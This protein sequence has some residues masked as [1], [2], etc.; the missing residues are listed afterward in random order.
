MSNSASIRLTASSAS[1]EIGGA[2][3]PRL[4]LAAISARTKNLRRE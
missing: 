3:L 1:G 2:F 4:A